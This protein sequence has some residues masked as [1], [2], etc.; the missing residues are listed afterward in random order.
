[1]T[2]T[3]TYTLTPV[4]PDEQHVAVISQ[5]GLADERWRVLAY[6]GDDHPWVLRFDEA[7]EHTFLIPM[8]ALF[9]GWS[10]LVET[11]NAYVE[12]S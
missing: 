4:P 1:M 10:A 5:E 11:G 7:D 9:A 6:D 8:G 3:T 2:E 12:K